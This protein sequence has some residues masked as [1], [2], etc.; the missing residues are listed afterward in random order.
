MSR[1]RSLAK[2]YRDPFMDDLSIILNQMKRDAL[3]ATAVKLNPE[4]ALK[5]LVCNAFLEPCFVC[6][7]IPNTVEVFFV[8]EE[9]AKFGQTVIFYTLCAECKMDMR[10]VRTVAEKLAK[11]LKDEN[12]RMGVC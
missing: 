11:Q 8:P 12:E 9:L 2:P 4:Q 7:Q 3:G 10:L 1:V 6:D 5:A